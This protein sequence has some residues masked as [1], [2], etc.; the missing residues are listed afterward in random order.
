MLLNYLESS[1]QLGPVTLHL[2]GMGLVL[3]LVVGLMLAWREAH[4][5]NV[6]PGIITEVV[7]FLIIGGIIGARLLSVVL[8]WEQFAADPLYVFRIHEGG[9]AA[10]GGIA[11]GIAAGMWY[12][13][14]KNISF[15]L[16]ADIMA[17]SLALGEALARLGCDVYGIPAENAPWP[18]MVQGLPF[19]NIPLYMFVGG[20]L[21]FAVVWYL[22]GHLQQRG[23]LF[24]A[25]LAGYFALRVIVDYFREPPEL[26]LMNLSQAGSLALLVVVIAVILLRKRLVS[27]NLQ[28]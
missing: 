13:R 6:D 21:L 12:T 17:P 15:W 7:I 14:R 4:R 24:L 18:R 11:G 3:A 25:Y 5:K 26:G 19:H 8:N 1:Y 28:G 27:G 10:F 9:L 22:R 23:T 20:I 2:Y 16:L